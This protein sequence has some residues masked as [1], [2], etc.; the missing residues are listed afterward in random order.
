M[1][2]PKK[3][4]VPKGGAS[5]RGSRRFV[6]EPEIKKEMVRRAVEQARADEERRNRLACSTK[7]IVL[8]IA[9]GFL[10]DAPDIPKES[11]AH[12]IHAAFAQLIAENKLKGVAPSRE[13]IL[14]WIMERVEEVGDPIPF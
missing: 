14:R 5:R 12:G 13:T 7:D 4:K 11:M 2:G 9:V 6:V 1:A 3:E 10:S 8:E